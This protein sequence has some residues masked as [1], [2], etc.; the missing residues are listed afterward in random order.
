MELEERF[1]ED[2]DVVG[3][4]INADG[5]RVLL[6]RSGFFV[7][8]PPEGAENVAAKELRRVR[9]KTQSFFHICICQKWLK[10]RWIGEL[11]KTAS[12]LS[13]GDKD[14]K[15]YWDKTQH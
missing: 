12:G 9:H 14:W 3:Y 13:G 7:W 4:G 6:L 5:V 11:H 8:S 1:V 2:H 10:Y 15:P